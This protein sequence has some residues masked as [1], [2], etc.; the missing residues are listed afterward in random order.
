MTPSPRPVY[1]LAV[2]GA[3]II[4][5]AHA[6]VAARLGKRVVV[7]ERSVRANG[8]SIRNFGFVT[9]TGQARGQSWRLASRTR[10][11]W[12]EIAPQADIAVEDFTRLL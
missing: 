4:G 8:A 5:L 11:V 2:I 9:V 7:I 12:A 10:D 6:Y 1:D 3:G